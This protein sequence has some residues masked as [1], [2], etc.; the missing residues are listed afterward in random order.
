MVEGFK[1]GGAYKMD[2]GFGIIISRKKYTGF[3][4]IRGTPK[5]PEI[6]KSVAIR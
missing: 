4:F 2:E 1:E 5:D 3:S 6:C